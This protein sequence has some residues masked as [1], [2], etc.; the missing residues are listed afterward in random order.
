MKSTCVNVEYANIQFHSQTFLWQSLGPS[1]LDLV[2]CAKHPLYLFESDILEGELARLQSQHSVVFCHHSLYYAPTALLYTTL[3]S[4][5]TALSVPSRY[6][7]H[8][9]DSWELNYG[10][11]VILPC[12]SLLKSTCKKGVQRA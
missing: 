5:A 2:T 11:P 9:P 12:L 6:L 7:N 8:R 1:M 4:G 3:L 10:D